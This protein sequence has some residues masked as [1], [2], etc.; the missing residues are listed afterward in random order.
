M[1][2]ELDLVGDIVPLIYYIRALYHSRAF[3]PIPPSNEELQILSIL[4]EIP[5]RYPEANLD[6]LPIRSY[7]I[8]LVQNAYFL[9]R[10]D[11]ARFSCPNSDDIVTILRQK[12]DNIMA[13]LHLTNFQQFTF[14]S[15]NPSILGRLMNLDYLVD[16]EDAAVGR[17]RPDQG[18]Q[19]FSFDLDNLP[20][21]EPLDTVLEL[22]RGDTSTYVLGLNRLLCYDIA[23]LVENAQWQELVSMFEDRLFPH[24]LVLSGTVHENL[25]MLIYAVVFRLLRG[26]SDHFQ[27]ADLVRVL[28]GHFLAVSRKWS[29]DEC[30]W[31][32][33]TTSEQSQRLLGARVLLLRE[34]FTAVPSL[35]EWSN[36]QESVELLLQFLLVL[37]F[38]RFPLASG[39]RAV[40]VI[41]LFFRGPRAHS[42]FLDLFLLGPRW[43]GLLLAVQTRLAERIFLFLDELRGL[44]DEEA[45]L[46]L[47]AAITGFVEL[48]S[49]F[50]RYQ[51]HLLLFLREIRTHQNVANLK[52]VP[53]VTNK[54]LD[55]LEAFN[56][57]VLL[58]RPS[59]PLQS[60]EQLLIVLNSSAEKSVDTSVG[61]IWLEELIR[62][63]ISAIVTTPHRSQEW[64]MSLILLASHLSTGRAA[65]LQTEI[66]IVV[67][68]SLTTEELED[69]EP[70]LLALLEQMRIVTSIPQTL[71]TRVTLIVQKVLTAQ[72]VHRRQA[73]FQELIS[74]PST[75]LLAV[76][77]AVTLIDLRLSSSQSMEIGR[78]GLSL[79][80]CVLQRLFDRR[81]LL[82]EDEVVSG[83]LLALLHY[84]LHS[85]RPFLETMT[86]TPDPQLAALSFEAALKWS[87][88]LAGRDGDRRLINN[89]RD[90]LDRLL[91][92]YLEAEAQC[93]EVGL[94]SLKV[95]REAV[96]LMCCD[97][98][99]AE[100][101][102]VALASFLTS[103][104]ET[105]ALC[106]SGLDSFRSFFGFLISA[107]R[108]GWSAPLFAFIDFFCDFSAEGT[109]ASRRVVELDDP[110]L[111]DFGGQPA[112]PYLFGILI[113]FVSS[114]SGKFTFR[115]IR[116]DLEGFQVT[117]IRLSCED[118]HAFLQANSILSFPAQC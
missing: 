34:A 65:S 44:D 2:T 26:L 33:L 9:S 52:T 50:G 4:K 37:S 107:S 81:G 39:G 35:L 116:A 49:G 56:Q 41:S 73:V 76:Q 67:A 19:F 85:L 48:F 28:L 89:L 79:V 24:T 57:K 53:E 112:F 100:N 87:C 78:E 11:P 31:S 117:E 64:L 95:L 15:F 45:I 14:D 29:G 58:L 97:C 71:Q 63:F 113:A 72:L 108:M 106:E 1:T 23:D 80:L 20:A 5:R 77:L 55:G 111:S 98:S 54:D 61:I 88:L 66:F 36:G 91:P 118:V 82:F 30:S 99:V 94:L 102:L 114:R 43:T 42:N 40:S 18:R 46:S 16:D 96:E 74:R 6:D 12:S 51:P 83:R 21:Y 27:S 3:P 75:V 103:S 22:L 86:F 101:A 68:E 59:P 7:L 17:A 115:P 90:L 13:R 110:T 69:K 8:E 105:P 109:V 25:L 104:P 32:R 84:L 93:E 62:S 92:A 70:I 47:L 38:G 60:V 10:V